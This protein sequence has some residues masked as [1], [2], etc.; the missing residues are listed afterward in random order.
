MGDDVADGGR[1]PI[2]VGGGC[3][4]VSEQA[5]SKGTVG[6]MGNK[7][8]PTVHKSIARGR[9]RMHGSRSCSCCCQ[10]SNEGACF[11]AETPPQPV[12]QD[13]HS[14]PW[15]M[16]TGLFFLISF[17]GERFCFEMIYCWRWVCKFIC[18]HCLHFTS[19]MSWDE[20]FDSTPRGMACS[21]V[22]SDF[23]HST[24]PCFFKFT[25]VV[26]N[27]LMQNF[28]FSGSVATYNG[29]SETVF[30]PLAKILFVACLF[31]WS[32]GKHR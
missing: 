9:A 25:A 4:V 11:V 31:A 18:F 3:D 26:S 22:A 8:R 27:P 7:G 14:F 13:S 21:C 5:G 28:Y 6:C 1:L 20:L 16:L 29:S 19:R 32:M 15:S 30:G 17:Q 10:Y 23:F 12:S 2:N 24:V